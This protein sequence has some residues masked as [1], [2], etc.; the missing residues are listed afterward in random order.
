[1]NETNGQIGVVSDVTVEKDKGGSYTVPEVE[2]S[3]P[4][5]QGG[6]EQ[7]ERSKRDK[8]PVF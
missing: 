3:F 6:R 1:M 4:G 7:S 8:K 2:K 5:R